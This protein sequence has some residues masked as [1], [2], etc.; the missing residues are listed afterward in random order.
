MTYDF[1]GD[2]HGHAGRLKILLR[3]LG[4]EKKGGVFEHP[5][6]ERIAVFLGDFIDRG[7]AI[8]ETLE[9][10][11]SMID[12][13]RALAIMGNHEYNAI[14]FH[15]ERPAEPGVW[16]RRR[17]DKNLFQY[18]E[19]LY[20][21][22]DH[23]GELEDYLLWFRTL[24]LWLDL[25]EVRA[26]HA[27]WHVPSMDALAGFPD[28][29][30]LVSDELLQ[31]CTVIGSNEYIAVEN[32][33]KGMEISLPGGATFTDPDGNVRSKMRARW[34]IG[35]HDNVPVFFGHYWFH[36]D[37]PAI[38]NPKV[39]CLDYSVAKGGFLAAYT[40]RGEKELQDAAFTV[41]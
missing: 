9:I 1:I 25:G 35:Y 34:W 36:D 20:Q 14:C 26:V 28:G 31:A 10:A 29:G 39:V 24:P 40:W 11:R 32:L 33:L 41:A 37:K 16:M 18:L 22:K 17:T 21:F 7:P 12:S 38:I 5:D 8:R 27:A 3:R 2:V 15:V 19:T 30:R 6:S 4:Y 13:K 23:R